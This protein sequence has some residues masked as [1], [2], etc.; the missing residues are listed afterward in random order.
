LFARDRF[1]HNA[2]KVARITAFLHYAC[3][4]I[5]WIKAGALKESAPVISIEQVPPAAATR[6]IAEAQAEQVE[7]IAFRVINGEASGRK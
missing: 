1:H 4:D 6:E 2:Q 3:V 5:L 7:G